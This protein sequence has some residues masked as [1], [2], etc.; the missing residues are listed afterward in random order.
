M[1]NQQ[2][3]VCSGRTRYKRM[4]RENRL[5]TECVVM[6]TEKTCLKPGV[7]NSDGGYVGDIKGESHCVTASDYTLLF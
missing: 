2:M 4:E 7:N 6:L 3:D 5:E 1:S